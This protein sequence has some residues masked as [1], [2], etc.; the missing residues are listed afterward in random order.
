LDFSIFAC[1]SNN[2]LYNTKISRKKFYDYSFIINKDHEY[3]KL[4][5]NDKDLLD[6]EIIKKFYNPKSIQDNELLQFEKC[7]ELAI[8]PFKHIL[9]HKGTKLTNFNLITL[10][11]KKEDWNNLQ[12][13][14]NNYK[15]QKNQQ[16]I[17]LNLKSIESQSTI[18]SHLDMDD[19]DTLHNILLDYLKDEER[20]LIF[21][22]E[23]FNFYLNLGY[24]NEEILINL[25]YYYLK[26]KNKILKNYSNEN[27][28]KLYRYKLKSI[29]DSKFSINYS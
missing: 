21:F 23:I 2:P 5:R 16:K 19:R 9:C 14:L 13:F 12:N 18:T 20:E 7:F 8:A 4:T 29:L 15:Y 24:F 28:F 25:L 1:N 10:N 26:Y 11:Y 22:Y 17:I 3:Y 6:I 27:Y